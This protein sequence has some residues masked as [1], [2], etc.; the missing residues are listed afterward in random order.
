[1]IKRR[2]TE[3]KKVFSVQFNTETIEVMGK[4]ARWQGMTL[5]E[6][7]RYAVKRLIEDVNENEDFK[8]HYK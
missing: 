3:D 8:R 5:Q 7:T 4:I 2:C 1:M 6:L